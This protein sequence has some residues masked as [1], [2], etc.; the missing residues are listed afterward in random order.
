MESESILVVYSLSKMINQS[1][2]T[3]HAHPSGVGCFQALDHDI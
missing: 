1:L 3:Q 2:S